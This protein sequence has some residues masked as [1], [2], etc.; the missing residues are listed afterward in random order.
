[1]TNTIAPTH[2]AAEYL[3]PDQIK[4]F[5]DAHGM[6]LRAFEHQDATLLR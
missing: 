1:M 3:R 5:L 4:E 6:V 2:A